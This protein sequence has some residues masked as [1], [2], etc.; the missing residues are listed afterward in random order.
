MSLTRANTY[1]RLPSDHNDQRKKLILW[2]C[3]IFL[4]LSLATLS[5]FV[6]IKLQEPNPKST[7]S[8]IPHSI[9]SKAITSAAG[10]SPK[11]PKDLFHLSVQLSITH[12][13]KA[14]T[15]AY[16]PT[17]S[18]QKLGTHSPSGMH[19][20]IEL[21]DSSLMQLS[22][23]VDPKRSSTSDDINTW[24]S[25]ALTNQVTCI[26]GLEN[27]QSPTATAMMERARN[28]T[29][30]ISNSLALYKSVVG[31]V[32]SGGTRK[33]LSDGFPEWV[34]VA[35]RKL[36]EASVDELRPHAVVAMDGTGT[37][38]T[39]SEALL[40][41]S[42]AGEGSGRTVI[43]L[44]AG[45][46]NEDVKI[47]AKQKNVML[48]GDGKGVTVITGHKNAED[49]SSTFAS[50]TVGITGEGFIARDITFV[51]SAGPSKN[52][53]V[54]L[55][56]GSDR[57]VIY[58]CSIQGYQDTLYTLSNRQFYRETDIYGTV[59]FIFGNSAVVFQSCNINAIKS[60]SGQKNYVTAQGR[61]DANQNTGISIHNCRISGTADTYLGRPWKQYSRTVIMQSSLS[62]INSAGWHPW[63]GSFALKT[64]Y[65]AEY[66]NSGPSSSTSGRVGWP[67]Y[68]SSISASEASKFTVAGFISGNQWLPSTGVPFDAGL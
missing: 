44:K 7:P 32:K 4:L 62:G 40:A 64:L 49:G 53:A 59:D 48:V 19:D 41:V 65:Y 57:S 30:L 67:G 45:T 47:P 23:V 15:L 25:A 6:T 36:L 8:H 50:A 11:S 54:A 34:S 21:L 2:A 16:D 56:V 22:D 14:L 17:V 33:L 35:D 39:I 60:G 52:Q 38:A 18:D 24:L 13:R 46:Y 1:Q 12:A 20:C 66:M 26:D 42:A 3:S 5:C 9:V 28:L 55:R 68:H 51:N 63:S 43:H 61:S 10:S 27:I 58:R 31:H 37:H 29:K